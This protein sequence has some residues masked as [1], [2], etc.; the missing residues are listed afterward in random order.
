MKLPPTPCPKGTIVI[1]EGKPDVG[2]WLMPNNQAP[3]ELEDF[4]SE[5]IPEEDLVW[6]KSEQYIDEIPSSSRRFPEDKAHK[7]KVHAWLAARRHPGLM[8]LAIREGDLEVSGIL[9]QDFAEW[10]RRLFV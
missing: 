9:C 7:A 3:G 2:I 5:M 10:L 8:G 6:P 1:T 4:V